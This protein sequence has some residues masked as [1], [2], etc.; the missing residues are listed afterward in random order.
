MVVGIKQAQKLEKCGKVIV[1]CLG[2][3]QVSR[4]NSVTKVTWGTSQDKRTMT[5]GSCSVA[6][7]LIAN[8]DLQILQVNYKWVLG[9]HK[10]LF[11]IDLWNC[12]APKKPWLSDAHKQRRL[13][14]A[15]MYSH[16][17]IEDRKKRYGVMSQFFRL[18]RTLAR[19]LFAGSHTENT[20]GIA[21]NQVSSQTRVQWWFEVRLQVLTRFLW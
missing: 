8:K 7:S 9:L 4:Y 21:C 19:L 3:F 12:V 2:E 11:M 5:K 20:H 14:F 13:C 10:M 17:T 18:A 6:L 15:C 16:W 1:Y